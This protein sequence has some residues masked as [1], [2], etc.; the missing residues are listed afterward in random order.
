MPSTWFSLAVHSPDP[1]DLARFWAD[2]LGYQIV[3]EGPKGE[4]AIAKDEFSNPGMVFVPLDEP[5][6]GKSRLHVELNPDDQDAEVERLIGLGASR[7]DIGQPAD[8]SWVVL[9][10]PDGNEFCVLAPWRHPSLAD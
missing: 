5:R 8:A 3:F 7:V 2:A 10:D 1:A 4:V 6:Q 9:A